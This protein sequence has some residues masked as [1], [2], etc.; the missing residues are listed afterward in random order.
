MPSSHK[1]CSAIKMLLASEPNT[2]RRSAYYQLDR[3]C[4]SL[5]RLG[6]S[7]FLFVGLK[8][9]PRA[10]INSWN[11][12]ERV[13]TGGDAILVKDLFERLLQLVNIIS[14]KADSAYHKRFVHPKI[15]DRGIIV[16]FRLLDD[17]P[18]EDFVD[19]LD[20]RFPFHAGDVIHS[21]LKSLPHGIELRNL[22]QDQ[23]VIGV[24]HCRSIFAPI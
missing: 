17:L 18:A 9:R 15:A 6:L 2:I 13:P 21:T 14:C 19:G 1:S 23:S 12:V 10:F 5:N 7:S 24:D 16:C 20:R 22:V 4:E 3:P 8:T 11:F